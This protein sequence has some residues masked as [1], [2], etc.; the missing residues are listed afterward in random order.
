LKATAIET[1]ALYPLPPIETEVVGE[2]SNTTS[3]YGLHPGTKYNITI[4][5]SNAQG[6]SNKAYTIDWT[7]IGPPCKPQTPK[8]LQKNNS[9]ILIE[10]PP[11]N[12]ENGP[13]TYYHVVVIQSGTI[14]PIGNDIVYENYDRSNREGL[15]YYITGKF[16][17]SDYPQYKLFEV[18]DGRVIGGY[19]NAPLDKQF[20]EPQVRKLYNICYLDTITLMFS[21]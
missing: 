5:V 20:G 15:G 10:I 13:L 2:M 12:S 7:R 9:T 18:G 21:Y 6:S 16:D 11:G 3:L 4:F 8:I 19:Y 14:P 17:V 1:R